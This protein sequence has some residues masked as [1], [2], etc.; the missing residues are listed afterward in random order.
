[1]PRLIHIPLLV[2]LAVFSGRGAET[3]SKPKHVFDPIVAAMATNP[4]GIYPLGRIWTG[5]EKITFNDAPLGIGNPNRTYRFDAAQVESNL[6][7]P[8]FN[9]RWAIGERGTNGLTPWTEYAYRPRLPTDAELAAIR[10]DAA[11][12]NSFGPGIRFPTNLAAG[13]S[14][15]SRHFTL[16]TNNTIETLRVYFYKRDPGTNFQGVTI[17]RATIRREGVWWYP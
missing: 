5:T 15:G 6:R 8:L 1:M 17:H 11:Y 16:G 4:A 13:T 3:S 10:N 9:H 7:H 14:L 12:T 2:L